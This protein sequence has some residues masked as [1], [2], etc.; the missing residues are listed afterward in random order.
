[1]VRSSLV[2]AAFKR[3]ERRTSASRICVIGRRKKA[4]RHHASG[5]SSEGTLQGVLTEEVLE[6]MALFCLGAQAVRGSGTFPTWMEPSVPMVMRCT[7]PAGMAEDSVTLSELW[8]AGAP[9]FSKG[10]AVSVV[11]EASA[12]VDGRSSTGLDAVAGVAGTGAGSGVGSGFGSGV[13]WGARG[14]SGSRWGAFGRS[15]SRWGASSAAGFAASSFRAWLSRF[16][17][18]DQQKRAL[19]SS[20][21]P[22]CEQNIAASRV[23]VMKPGTSR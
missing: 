12:D 11:L 17:P 3:Q 4:G 5:S 1:M 14:R 16:A 18:H 2:V 8:G 15:G 20:G 21:A 19:S 22:H 7:E 23:K 9:G 6:D 13:E 10:V